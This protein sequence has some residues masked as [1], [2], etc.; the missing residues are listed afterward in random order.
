MR[1]ILG[2]A[3]IIS[4]RSHIKRTEVCIKM[5]VSA[6]KLVGHCIGLR[7]NFCGYETGGRIPHVMKTG[8]SII[9][10]F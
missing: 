5:R 2:E 3:K 6:K 8:S 4:G 10:Y 7:K 1:S 9:L